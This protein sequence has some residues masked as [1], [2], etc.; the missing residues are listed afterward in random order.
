MDLQR[1]HTFPR[2]SE[3]LAVRLTC[4]APWRVD[5]VGLLAA[6]GVALED[7]AAVGLAVTVHREPLAEV[8]AWSVESRPHLLLGVWDHVVEL[9]PWVSPGVGPCARCV[10]ADTLDAVRRQR[11]LPAPP[12]W[13]WAGAVAGAAADLGA[14]A[15]GRTPATW[16]MRWRLTGEPVPEGV[17]SLRHAY[18]GCTWWETA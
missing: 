1:S 7:G 12:A 5:L 16:G 13:L 15:A 10:E 17:R 9:G 2:T 18:C 11:A 4:P 3:S 8:D 6:S 14:W